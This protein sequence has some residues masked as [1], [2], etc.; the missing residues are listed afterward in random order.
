MSLTLSLLLLFDKELLLELLLSGLA[1]CD[2]DTSCDTSGVQAARP[3]ETKAMPQSAKNT[4]FIV[5]IP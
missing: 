4:C 5:F 3:K 2:I 1:V